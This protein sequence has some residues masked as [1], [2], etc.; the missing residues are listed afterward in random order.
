MKMMSGQIAR[1]IL[2]AGLLFVTTIVTGEAGA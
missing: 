2:V 1:S